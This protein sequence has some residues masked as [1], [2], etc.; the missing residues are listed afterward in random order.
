MIEK[1]YETDSSIH[2]KK[3][4]GKTLISVFSS[5]ALVSKNFSVWREEWA[6]GYNSMNF[7][8]FPNLS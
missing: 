3:R 7:R 6:L 2:V 4:Y 1:A 5:S 8:D